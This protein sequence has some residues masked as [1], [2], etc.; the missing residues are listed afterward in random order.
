MGALSK[1]GCVVALD[2]FQYFSRKHLYSFTSHLQA[3][4]DELSAQ[5]A[6]VP[7]GL[8][9]LGSLHTELVALLEDRTAPL[10]NRTTDQIE[11]GH[12]DI[13]SI[14]DILR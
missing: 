13:A 11:L 12:L 8:F 2:E 14:R 7:G 3:V 9:V 4:V 1:A 6:E 10:Y 5:A